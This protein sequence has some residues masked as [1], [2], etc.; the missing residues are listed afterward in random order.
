MPCVLSPYY[1]NLGSFVL[2]YFFFFL[3]KGLFILFLGVWF[4]K[5]FWSNKKHFQ[6]TKKTLF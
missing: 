5:K 3:K 4:D 2:T 6:L 1:S